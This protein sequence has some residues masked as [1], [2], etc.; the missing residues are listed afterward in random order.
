MSGT[1]L[2]RLPL[3]CAMLVV[4]SPLRAQGAPP[5]GGIFLLLP[6]GA[7]A[8]ALGRAMTAQPGAESVFWNPAGLGEL[9]EGRLLLY[10]GDYVA[11]SGTA[12]SGLMSRAG[13]G[14][15]GLT[16]QLLDV[17]EQDL[18]DEQGNV[19]G[20]ITVRNHLGVASVATRVWS[21]LNIGFNFKVIQFRQSCRGQCLDPGVTATTYAVDAGIQLTRLAGL[22]LRVGAMVAHAG[23]RFQVRNEEQA[24]PLPTRMRISATYEVLGRLVEVPELELHVTA[25]VEDRWRD[26]G[27]PALY[28]GTEF[29]ATVEQ[30]LLLARAGYVKGN[31]EQLDGAA[32][33]VGFRYDRFDV[34]VAKSLAATIIDESEPVHVTFGLVF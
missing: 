4:A 7:K 19:L 20:T 5:E 15:M 23:P 29:G 24:D 28:L 31:G 30:A 33:G 3:A 16:Y 22:P 25:E 1:L 6:V 18:T 9:S 32:V 13:I 11:G 14:A 17:G 21:R 26:P 12:A 10:R 27:S 8:I 34:G 2:R